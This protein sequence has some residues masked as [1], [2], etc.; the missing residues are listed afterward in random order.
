MFNKKSI[1]RFSI[2][3]LS[4]GA[5]SVLIGV[6]F[7][8]GKNEV[9]ADQ[10]KPN[11]DDNQV[12]EA[13]SD[14]NKQDAKLDTANVKKIVV[15]KNAE[16]SN[17]EK[18][19]TAEN[20]DQKSTAA[21]ADP[22]IKQEK[23]EEA[24]ANAPKKETVTEAN[25]Q[26]NAD[27]NKKDNDSLN[28]VPGIK[29]HEQLHANIQTV[30]VVTGQP[31]KVFANGQWEELGLKDF[32]SF[33]GN[34][35]ANIRTYYDVPGYKLLDDLSTLTKDMKAKGT[36]L[37][38]DGKDVNV[39]LHYAPY[40]DIKI[41]YV[42]E[43]SN[44]VI[45]SAIMPSWRLNGD[46]Y[47]YTQGNKKA[48]QAADYEALAIDIPGY[49]LNSV[50]ILTGKIGKQVQSKGDPNYI[51]LIFKYKK[52]DDNAEATTTTKGEDSSGA[53]IEN[54]WTPLPG[55][56]TVS[57]DP[58]KTNLDSYGNVEEKTQNLIKKYQNQ[59]YT[60][61]GTTGVLKNNAYYNYAY[62]GTNIYLIPN[63]PVTVKYVDQ[64][65]KEIV[66]EDVIEFNKDNPDQAN[67]GINNKT[68]WHAKGTWTAKPKE[69]AGY[70]LVQVKGA[71]SGNFT[72]YKYITT[73][74]YAKAA[75]GQVVYIDDTTKTTLKKD[76]LTGN[77]GDSI[78]YTT[79]DQIND[80][81]AKGYKLVSNNFVDGKEIFKENGNDFEVHLAHDLVP[82]NPEHPGK[83]GEPINPNDPTGPK[84]PA[85][86]AKTD[87]SKTITRTINYVD[88]N[89]KEL[90]NPVKQE[91]VLTASGELDKVTG[92][93]TKPLAW[94]EDSFTA[95]KAEMIKG[96]DLSKIT[97][98]GTI[99]YTVNKD[100]SIS[101]SKVT[102]DNGNTVVT[103]HFVKQAQPTQPSNPTQ[104]T[105]P[106]SPTTPEV[107]TNPTAPQPTTPIQPTVPD[108]NITPKPEDPITPKN[109]TMP[110]TPE[111]VIP[112]PNDEPTE[113]TN[114][115]HTQ[116]T[117]KPHPQTVR[118]NRIATKKI[119]RQLD[120]KAS[121]LPE[122]GEDD[123][124][125]AAIG[126]ALAGSIAIIGLAGR[127]RHN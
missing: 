103:L 106:S 14:P 53:I 26:N 39:T 93:W 120:N 108:Q 78:A 20:S 65:G 41:E 3:K 89:G 83:P 35:V 17:S 127:K 99:F 126:L 27:S 79:A 96:Y 98:E 124:N 88:E 95:V 25:K 113:P 15:Q 110:T 18:E 63:K 101:A 19:V 47:A 66:P 42:D 84:Y 82:V 58:F 125:L 48:P 71:E 13:T 119:A 21:N 31:V 118:E 114:Q 40:S 56:F 111:T 37:L 34:L 55:Q 1:K 57:G 102:K 91:V 9:K 61:I 28:K 122:T 60:Y 109:P 24:K 16:A 105:T 43:D 45:S 59:G 104:P 94:T 77:V 62:Y 116:I 5:A 33:D 72:P 123:N 49:K 87:L 6:T 81:L 74:I 23:T 2:R 92:K 86:T 11:Q 112:H 10:V 97:T 54:A 107:P 46:T 38:F 76:A 117:V 50:P 32:Y 29:Q 12:A 36:E 85:D 67:N 44:D 22:A 100:G 30:N 4:I 90:I 7:L 80:Y 69:I 115:T 70:N 64:N 75:S 121:Q 68:Y 51:K 8:N 73:F 52:T